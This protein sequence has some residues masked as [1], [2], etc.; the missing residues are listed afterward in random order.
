MVLSLGLADHNPLSRCRLIT[1]ISA[2]AKDI[3][4]RRLRIPPD[5]RGLA[6]FG[7]LVVDTVPSCVVVRNVVYYRRTRNR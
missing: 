1:P 7:E 2:V 4:A 5:R 6:E 3:G